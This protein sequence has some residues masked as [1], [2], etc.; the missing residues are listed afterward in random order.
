MSD[1]KQEKDTYT[2]SI[3][4]KTRNFTRW[5]GQS[6]DLLQSSNKYTYFHINFFFFLNKIENL[7]I[8]LSV[9]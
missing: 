6:S 2:Y 8:I 3:F 9:C 5:K 4:K 7:S 1:K